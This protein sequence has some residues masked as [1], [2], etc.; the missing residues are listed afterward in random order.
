MPSLLDRVRDVPLAIVDVETTGSSARYG[1]RVT[2]VGIAV[3]EDGQVTHTYQQLVNP[4]RRISPGVVRLTGITDAMCAV[5]P[6]FRQVCGEVL[7]LLR[8]RVVVGHNVN[9]DLSFLEHECAV[10]GFDLHRE[11]AGQHVLDTVRI[12]RGK[13]GRGGNGLQRLAATYGVH[14]DSAHRALADC[15]TTAA[16]LEHLLNPVGWDTPFVDVL[17][18]QKGAMKL[19][20]HRPRPDTSR[21]TQ[22][23]IELPFELQEALESRG[24]VRMEYL[25][26]RKKSTE[27]LIDPMDVKV[28]GGVATLVG[29]CHLRGTMRTFKLD[30]I[31]RLERADAEPAVA[32][33]DPFGDAAF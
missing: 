3:V 5:E 10:A 18:L 26:A 11:L 8:G 20:G 23:Q 7:D 6:S 30:R 21:M 31:V 25:D 32:D 1:D 22:E 27:R 16:V 13:R 19:T 28:A 14:V 12:A 2:E 9:F 24:T 15:L 17:S 33:D 4:G 29:Y